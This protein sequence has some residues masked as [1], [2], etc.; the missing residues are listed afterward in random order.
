LGDS[1]ITGLLILHALVAVALLGAITHQAIAVGGDPGNG[2][3]SFAARYRSVDASAYAGAIALLFA[4]STLIGASLYP[5][6]R[7]IVRPVLE[8]NNLR[9]ANGAFELKE[10]FAALGLLMLPAYWAAWSRPLVPEYTA[11]RMGLTWV[12]AAI[13]WWNFLIG[14]VLNNIKGLFH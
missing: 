4:A 5:S 6:Y 12:L 9:M 1:L 2:K 11:A 13:V 3:K 8:L 7:M 14:D 10:H